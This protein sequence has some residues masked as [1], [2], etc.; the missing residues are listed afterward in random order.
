VNPRFSGQVGTNLMTFLTRLGIV[1]EVGPRTVLAFTGE[2]AVQ[3]V[4]RGEA[5]IVLAFG[6]QILPV[7]GVR[8]LGPLPAP[9]QVPTSYAAAVGARSGNPELAHAVLNQSKRLTVSA[10][11]GKA[12]LEP[13]P[14]RH[15]IDQVK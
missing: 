2:E 7:P 15:P 8:W 9:L 4:A 1:E 6:S 3:K 14:G 13:V 5:E 10:S 12:G 11:S